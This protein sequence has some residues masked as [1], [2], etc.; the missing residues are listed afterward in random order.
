[1]QVK[2]RTYITLVLLIFKLVIRADYMWDRG[3]WDCA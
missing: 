1:M 2:Y 3:A